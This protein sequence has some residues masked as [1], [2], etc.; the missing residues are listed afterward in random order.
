MD[1]LS[2][3]RV[4]KALTALLAIVVLVVVATLLLAGFS[5]YRVLAPER[6]SASFDPQALL[7]NPSVMEISGRGM[8]AREAVFFP[9]QTN[10]PTILLAHGYRSHRGA[11]LTMV[12]ALQD[13]Q[14]NVLL[15]DFSGHGGARGSTS[16]GY[17][18]TGELL[19]AVETV[20]QREDV[21]RERFGIWGVDMGAYAALAAAAADKR[22]RVVAAD[23]AYNTPADLLRLQIDRSGVGRFPLV[24]T[25]ARWG[26]V[27]ASLT[28]RSSPALSQRVGTM[29]GVAKLFIQARDNPVLAEAT[30]QLFQGAAEPR[31]QVLV[32]K[33]DYAAMT[34]EEKREYEGYVVS[35][36][37]Q[38]LPPV[39]AAPAAAPPAT[40]P[41]AKAKR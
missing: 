37:L 26:F 28:S 40:R 8:R 6:V 31:Q 36:F 41:R 22:I 18:E 11:L 1:F 5:L 21:D 13:N 34:D 12:T 33:S 23:S 29:S 4:A 25:L 20:A 17:K 38:H 35:F 39:A 32:P 24:H 19:A 3:S 27:L 30:L 7:G 10:A 2:D 9:G 15:F 14:Y 16:L